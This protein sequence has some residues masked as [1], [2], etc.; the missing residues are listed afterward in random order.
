MPDGAKTLP[1]TS[2]FPESGRTFKSLMPEHA[3]ASLR[4]SAD[5][6][7]AEGCYSSEP[8]IDIEAGTKCRLRFIEP[9][10]TM[11]AEFER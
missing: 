2:G 3:C 9:R 5:D 4:S 10:P 11:A 1:G 6:P 7:T 8:P